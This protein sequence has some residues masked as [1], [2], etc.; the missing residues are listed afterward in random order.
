M[1]YRLLI[2]GLLEVLL[3]VLSFVDFTDSVGYNFG[4]AWVDLLGI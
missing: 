1:F 4:L 2:L 3:S